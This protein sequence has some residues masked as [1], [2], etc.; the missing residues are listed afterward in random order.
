LHADPILR[1]RF[2]R[3]A[4]SAALLG[5]PN[6]ATVYELGP[7]GEQLFMAME[8]LDGVDLKLALATRTMSLAF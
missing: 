1:K 2:Q 7:D 5:H 8:L 4:Q 6:T 3:D